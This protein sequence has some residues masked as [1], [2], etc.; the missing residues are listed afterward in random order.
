[1]IGIDILDLERLDTSEN[2]IKKIAFE[3]EVDYI[4]KSPCLSLQKQRLGALF[5]VKEAVMKALEM[6]ENSGVGFK[7]IKLC[8]EENGK[9]F[10]ELFGKAKEKFEKEFSLK[11]I[12]VSLSHTPNYATAICIII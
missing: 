5:C 9:P 1:M 3:E 6:G 7:D 12:E 10:V 8:H 4:K 2:F 11:K